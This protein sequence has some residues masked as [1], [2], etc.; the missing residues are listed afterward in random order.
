MDPHSKQPISMVSFV[1]Y[2]MHC[3]LTIT[4]NRKQDKFAIVSNNSIF[5][6]NELYFCFHQGVKLL[7]LNIQIQYMIWLDLKWIF[8]EFNELYWLPLES[9]EPYHI[10]LWHPVGPEIKEKSDVIL[11]F[12]QK[13]IF[14]ASLA[15]SQT[16]LNANIEP[17]RQ[18]PN[19]TENLILSVYLAGRLVN[20]GNLIWA[21]Y[22]SWYL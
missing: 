18:D 14:P 17:H 16:H 8:M 6:K 3:N 4:G 21:I 11:T 13:S 1:W 20:N 2:K 15:A 5:M 19:F 12:I 22:Y 10:P 9:T 7:W